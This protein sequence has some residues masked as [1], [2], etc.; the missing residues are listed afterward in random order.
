MK[1]G[2]SPRRARGARGG[3]HR[4]RDQGEHLGWAE[5]TNSRV[6]AS[7]GHS[8]PRPAASLAKA[9]LHLRDGLSSLGRWGTLKRQS[10]FLFQIHGGTTASARARDHGA[11][12]VFSSPECRRPVL[13]ELAHTHSCEKSVCPSVRFVSHPRDP[14][15]VGVGQPP[16]SPLILM[17]QISC[18]TVTPH[19][20]FSLR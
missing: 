16:T 6:R 7:Q 19:S 12:T 8:H 14:P 15:P 20:I 5:R 4:L 9:S 10:A 2:P 18:Q 11:L 1:K 17:H 13:C 3:P